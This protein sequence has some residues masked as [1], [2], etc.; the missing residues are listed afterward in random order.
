MASLADIR[1]AIAT[2]LQTALGDGY[3]V[4]PYVLSTPSSQAVQIVPGIINKHAAMGDGAEWWHMRIQAFLGM[5]TDVG[6]QVNADLFL[7]DD[8]I[9]AAL[10][11]NPTLSGACDDLIVD[12]VEYRVWEH[13]S[14]G[15]I[16]GAEY[17]L[18]I[19]V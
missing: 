8:P 16:V 12:T 3:T 19:L 15:L 6:A 7:E 17:Q 10:E 5:T 11:T 1:T 18:R 9:S 2:T 14:V 4:S 13:R